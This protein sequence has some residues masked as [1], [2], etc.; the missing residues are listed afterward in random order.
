M[1][2]WYEAAFLCFGILSLLS[3]GG[4]LAYLTL[5]NNTSIE[6]SRVKNRI[7]RRHKGL[8]EEEEEAEG[9]EDGSGKDEGRKAGDGGGDGSPVP[10]EDLMLLRQEL[11]TMKMKLK[12]KEEL[13]NELAAS[14]VETKKDK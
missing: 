5:S 4:Y 1:M 13:L 6:L 9:R 7:K 11:E 12:E 8:P 14:T 2:Y 3:I 10:R